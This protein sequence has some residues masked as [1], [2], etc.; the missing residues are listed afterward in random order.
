MFQF[1]AAQKPVNDPLPTG[2]VAR[3][4]T[5]PLEHG[6]AYVG[7]SAFGK[8]LVS[9]GGSRFSK[10]PTT[11]R[12]KW[13]PEPVIR[14][15]DTT[16]GQ[17]LWQAAVPTTALRPQFA[18]AFAFAPDGKTLVAG[19]GCFVCIFDVKT[20]Q[21]LAR[22]AKSEDETIES[23]RFLRD[24]KTLV[25][26]MAHF[27]HYGGQFRFWD[28]ASGKLVKNLQPIFP[29][30]RDRTAEGDKLVHECKGG[31]LAP[32]GRMVIWFTYQ[33]TMHG[34]GHPPGPPREYNKVVATVYDT[35]SGKAIDQFIV[36]DRLTFSPNGAYFET[37]G[38]LWKTA[39][40]QKL[41]KLD[42]QF[43]SI[44]QNLTFSPDGNSVLYGQ[45]SSV[46]V[47]NIHSGKTV[48]NFYYPSASAWRFH[49]TEYQ[50][51]KPIAVSADS[52][53]L[54]MGDDACIALF[55]LTTGKALPAFPGRHSRVDYLA[56][57]LDGKSL[58]TGGGQ[59]L[60]AWDT[61]TWKETGRSAR[62]DMAAMDKVKGCALSA[63]A[64]TLSPLTPTAA[65]C[66]A[67]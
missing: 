28:L 24:G 60:C 55:D 49:E 41:R 57:S 25:A 12:E 43:H 22:L 36:L 54:A 56:F 39:G 38:W 30:V 65:F 23:V 42:K 52:K 35:E 13:E 5:K 14:L 40:W 44:Y 7:L 47:V 45:A 2:A 58:Q 53:V 6:P 63:L 32:D 67:S 17:L 31:V 51:R 37:E 11:G 62:F 10:D 61:E 8:L 19:C 34:E 50:F 48:H 4:G 29:P 46:Q 64:G 26:K 9:S 33:H 18:R 16:T 20:G 1:Q 15:W 3:L 21:E 59:F 66:C 27:G